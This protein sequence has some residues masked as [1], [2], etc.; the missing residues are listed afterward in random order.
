[1][2]TGSLTLESPN[3]PA[4]GDSPA[5][6]ERLATWARPQINTG[7]DPIPDPQGVAAMLGLLLFLVPQP[8]ESAE[9]AYLRLEEEELGVAVGG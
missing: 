2:R 5:E 8:E 9:A 1:M 7:Q 4:V 3:P 6:A